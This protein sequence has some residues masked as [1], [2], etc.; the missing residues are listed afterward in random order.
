[1]ITHVVSTS[2]VGAVEHTVE[3]VREL[4][5]ALEAKIKQMPQYEISVEHDFADGIYSRRI[6]IPAGVMLTGKVHKQNDL[7]IMV[8]GDI[9][10]LTENGLRRMTG[11][12]EF[13][14][15][16][17]IKQFGIAYEDTLWITVHHIHLTDLD[18]IEKELFEDEE[19]V[20]DFKT[21]KVKQEWIEKHGVGELSC[22]E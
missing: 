21:G 12:N 14:G 6:L 3:E 16:A 18:E 11:F 15:K 8:Y 1:M 19:C 13:P 17:G 22:L 9:D 2:G 5:Y 20:F 4:V 7:N 10:I